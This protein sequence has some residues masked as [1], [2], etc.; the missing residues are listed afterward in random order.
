MFQPLGYSSNESELSSAASYGWF[1][2]GPFT[3]ISG[4]VT[5]SLLAIIGIIIFLYFFYR[6]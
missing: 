3:Y 1:S 6:K 4:S 2:E 5:T